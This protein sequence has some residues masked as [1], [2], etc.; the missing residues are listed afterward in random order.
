METKRHVGLI[1]AA[2]LGTGF[3]VTILGFNNAYAYNCFNTHGENCYAADNYAP[4]L[5]VNGMQATYKAYNIPINSGYILSP[6]WLNLIDL[7][8]IELGMYDDSLNGPQYYWGTNGA[9]NRWGSPSDG[10]L[11]TFQIEDLNQDTIF[12]LKVDGTT[13]TTV[14]VGTSWS[15]LLNL[16]WEFTYTDMTVKM[17]DFNNKKYGRPDTGWVLWN[18]PDGDHYVKLTPPTGYYVKWCPDGP[19]HHSQHGQNGQ[20]TTC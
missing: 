16:G 19:F 7:T 6:M 11:H 5:S 15:N 1:V 9:I 8:F 10:S 2:I 17:N 14:D 3:A 4:N 13:H 18:D 12:S 20:S